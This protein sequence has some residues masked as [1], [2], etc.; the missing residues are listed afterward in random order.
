MRVIGRVVCDVSTRMRSASLAVPG[1]LS[2]ETARANVF[3]VVEILMTVLGFVIICCSDAVER[4]AVCGACRV[5][6]VD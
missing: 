6:F 3:D 4:R 2:S 5:L 1:G